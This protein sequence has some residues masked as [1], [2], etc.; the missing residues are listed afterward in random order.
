VE[1]IPPFLFYILSLFPVKT[2]FS[3]HRKPF[4]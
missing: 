1:A 3:Y 4:P 2:R